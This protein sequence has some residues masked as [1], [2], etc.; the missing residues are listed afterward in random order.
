M[1][2][3]EQVRPFLYWSD[4]QVRQALDM[5]SRPAAK[6]G[7]KIGFQFPG[8]G[9]TI[10]T[11]TESTGAPAPGSPRA[12]QADQLE[13]L[14]ADVTVRDTDVNGAA[15][16]CRGTAYAYWGVVRLPDGRPSYAAM[17]GIEPETGDERTMLALFGPRRNLIGRSTGNDIDPGDVRGWS[18]SS[19]IGQRL[20]LG[21]GEFDPP[22]LR[23]RKDEPASLARSAVTILKGQGVLHNGRRSDSGL[24]ASCLVSFL[25]RIYLWEPDVRFDGTD[26]YERVGIGAPV[27]IRAESSLEHLTGKTHIAGVTR[28]SKAFLVKSRARELI[29]GLSSRG[30]H[31]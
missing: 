21:I 12:E 26:R 18:S 10:E 19:E 4:S 13:K 25:A 24:I 27:W 1:K 28:P 30:K 29:E 31:A 23:L 17:F 3:I 6:R 2:P 7:A 14:L 22:E 15:H 20:L 16:Y 5:N 9:P 8:F 11:S